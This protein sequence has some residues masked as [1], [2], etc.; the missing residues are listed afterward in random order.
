MKLNDKS[1]S[2]IR[3]LPRIVRKQQ[4]MVAMKLQPLLS[5]CTEAVEACTSSSVLPSARVSIHSSV[6]PKIK[7]WLDAILFKEA[8]IDLLGEVA[9]RFERGSNIVVSAS[10]TGMHCSRLYISYVHKKAGNESNDSHFTMN[11]H[12][13]SRTREIVTQHQA[14][15]NLRKDGQNAIIEV[16]FP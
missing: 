10:S 3:R 9:K 1:I 12:S 4:V 13:D 8:L 15:M 14:A 7:L 11:D 16:K 6:S 2:P 5:V